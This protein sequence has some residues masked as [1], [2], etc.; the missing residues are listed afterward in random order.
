[1]NRHVLPNTVLAMYIHVRFNERIKRLYIL[2][3]LS[4]S[5][6]VT[7]V[8]LPLFKIPVCYAKK[9]VVQNFSYNLNFSHFSWKDLPEGQNI[10]SAVKHIKR[11]L[12]N[13]SG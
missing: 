5:E 3:Y 8:E 6:N 10:F 12:I 1:M 4:L 2:Y 9:I 13:L 11:G 7:S